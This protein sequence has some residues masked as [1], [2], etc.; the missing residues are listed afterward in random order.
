MNV[1]TKDFFRLFKGGKNGII[2]IFNYSK[3]GR[4]RGT[5]EQNNR[6]GGAKEQHGGFK[7][8]CI[9]NHI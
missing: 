6:G 2:K 4:K 9:N 8:K 7:L 1:G 5:G 3:E